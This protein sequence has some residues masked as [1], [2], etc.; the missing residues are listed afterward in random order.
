M[1]KSKYTMIMLKL[2]EAPN[3]SENRSTINIEGTVREEFKKMVPK[4]KEKS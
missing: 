2:I 1:I 4:G 3:D